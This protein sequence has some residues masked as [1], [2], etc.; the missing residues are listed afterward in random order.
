MLQKQAKTQSLE[1]GT[2]AGQIL[3]IFFFKISSRF[4]LR[5]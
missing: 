5:P 3:F 1:G 4:V 2:A